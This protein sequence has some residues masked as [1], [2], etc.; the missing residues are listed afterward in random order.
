MIALLRKLILR[1]TYLT[2]KSLLD[3][4]YFPEGK[5]MLLL[6]NHF[7][8]SASF[9][10]NIQKFLQDHCPVGENFDD[11]TIDNMFGEPIYAKDIQMITCPSSLKALKFY[12]IIGS[13]KDMW[14]YWK[15]IFIHIVCIFG[16]CKSEKGSKRN[17]GEQIL[18]QMSYQMINSLPATKDDIKELSKF[19]LD[20][21]ENLK[22]NDAIFIDY[23]ENT[24]NNINS[25]QMFIDLYNRN[26]NIIN[27]KLF[28]DFRKKEIH[29]Y[30]KYIKTEKSV[31]MRTIAL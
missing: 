30:I 27:T 10:C 26:C 12:D 19:E 24:A 21:I 4:G 22:N 8:K 20:Y 2:D 28:R 15:E 14:H 7:F 31:K 13:K 25:N 23:I 1:V 11:W 17:F 9:A 16:V 3:N 5:S 18:Q 6:R 29:N